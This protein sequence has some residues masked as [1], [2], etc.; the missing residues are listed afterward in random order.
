MSRPWNRRPPSAVDF[1]R[2]HAGAFD[3]E[4]LIQ[5]A[6]D[7]QCRY[8]DLP[9]SYAGRWLQWLLLHFGGSQQEVIGV[10]LPNSLPNPRI[11]LFWSSPWTVDPQPELYLV[12]TRYISRG[13]RGFDFFP[14]LKE[15]V[16]W[17][18]TARS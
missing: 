13:D 3:G 6:H 11:D 12:G 2:D 10:H 4:G 7:N 8:I 1:G 9:Q 16:G 18:N 17:L 14:A 15:I 5:I